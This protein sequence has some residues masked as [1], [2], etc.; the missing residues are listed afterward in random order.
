MQWP[1]PHHCS[2]CGSNRT[3]KFSQCEQ[4][5]NNVVKLLVEQCT[6]LQ[7]LH[8]RAG[9]NH[10]HLDTQGLTFSDGVVSHLLPNKLPQLK[11]LTLV[12]ICVGVGKH[13]GELVKQRP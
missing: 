1:S 10:L 8:L 3:L 5:T 12:C 2:Q 11:T 13:L 7:H 6:S 4:L 9:Y